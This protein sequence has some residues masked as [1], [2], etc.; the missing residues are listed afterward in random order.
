MPVPERDLDCQLW[1]Q[2]SLPTEDILR[3][4][5][6]FMFFCLFLKRIHGDEEKYKSLPAQYT[7][8]CPWVVPDNLSLFVFLMLAF[9]VWGF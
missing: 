8:E 4:L 2:A 3:A 6:E 7:R 1:Q 5:K 9:E